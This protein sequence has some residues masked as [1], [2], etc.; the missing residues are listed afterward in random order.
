LKQLEIIV[1]RLMGKLGAAADAY[2]A[3]KAHSE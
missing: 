2:R 3:L 1:E